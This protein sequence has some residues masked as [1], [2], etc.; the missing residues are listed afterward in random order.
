MVLRLPGAVS[1]DDLSPDWAWGGATGEGVRVAVI[2]S[3]I[4][5]DHPALEG[6]VDVDA[7]VAISLDAAGNLVETVGPHPDDFGHGTACAG[8]IHSM[9]PQA[10]ITSVKVLGAGLTGKA[11]AFLRGLGWAVEQGFDVIN[12]SLGTSRRDWALAFYEV[13]DQ[14][15]FRGSLVVTAANN[16]TRPSFPSLYASVVSVA[17]N[18]TTDPFRFHFN[19]EPPTE[20]LARGIDVDVAWRDGGRMRSTGNSYAAPHLSGI[21]AL[22]RSKHPELRPFQVKAVL[23]AT[24]ANVQE[25]P[26]AAG[27]LTSLVRSGTTSVRA[28]TALRAVQP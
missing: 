12:L 10:R 25:A 20:F 7:G 22:I 23:W 28:T 18:L 1:L 27:R 15:Y 4:E 6:C 2:D 13:C 11:A 16:V 26:R 5:A 21:A 14:A 8:I 9:A 19:P 24:A 17:C 3:G